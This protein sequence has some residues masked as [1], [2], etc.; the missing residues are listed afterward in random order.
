M[1]LLNCLQLFA[2][3]DKIKT[4]KN[5]FIQMVSQKISYFLTGN[6]HFIANLF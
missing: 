5:G 4:G 6:K 2:A 3:A 1:L